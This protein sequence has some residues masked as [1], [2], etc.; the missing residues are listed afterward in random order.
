MQTITQTKL[1]A[2]LYEAMQPYQVIADTEANIMSFLIG[3]FELDTALNNIVRAHAPICNKY[4]VAL[5]QVSVVI[6]PNILRISASFNYLLPFYDAYTSAEVS[7]LAKFA[8][9]ALNTETLFQDAYKNMKF[10]TV[11]ADDSFIFTEV[12]TSED[13]EDLLPATEVAKYN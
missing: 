1:L 4:N 7:E 9:K 6:Y 2:K 12:L 8:D 10:T 3:K 11:E 13:K 5:G